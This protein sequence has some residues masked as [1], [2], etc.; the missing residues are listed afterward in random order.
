MLAT[1]LA[2]ERKLNRQLS[3]LS[4]SSERPPPNLLAPQEISPPNTN[5]LTS[6]STSTAGKLCVTTYNTGY[7]LIVPNVIALVFKIIILCQQL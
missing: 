5:N 3:R 7:V 6:D 1:R 4:P 2:H